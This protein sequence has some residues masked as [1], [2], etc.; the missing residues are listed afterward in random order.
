M[1][2]GKLARGNGFSQDETNYLLDSIQEFHPISMDEWA[3]VE[4]RHMV[5]FPDRE[6]TRE[7]LRRK[8]QTLYLVK[9]ATG[10]PTCPPEVRRAKE[11]QRAIREKAEVSSV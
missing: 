11:L 4:R 7:S 1:S 6:R 8:F 10:D 5:A 2:K 9:K 3:A